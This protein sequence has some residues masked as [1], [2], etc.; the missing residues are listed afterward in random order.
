MYQ[1]KDW[2]DKYETFE[3]RKKKTLGWVLVPNR[4][5]SPKFARLITMPN[6]PAIFGVWN[7][8]LQLASRCESRGDLADSSGNAYDATDLAMTF[9]LPVEMVQESLDVLVKLGW[10]VGP[11]PSPA[12]SPAREPAPSP[13][14]N[15]AE[16]PT[17]TCT[18]AENAGLKKV[19]KK[20]KEE[21]TPSLQSGGNLKKVDRTNFAGGDVEYPTNLR[22]E[23]FKKA[24]DLWEKYHMESGRP[25]VDSQRIAH[26]SELSSMGSPNGIKSLNLA[27]KR[28][29]KAPAM[30]A[31]RSMEKS[32]EPDRRS[33]VKPN[34]VTDTKA[35]FDDFRDKLEDIVD[36]E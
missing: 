36:G 3:T 4:H 24:W 25:L 17:I 16:K 18:V 27:I 35:A 32:K 11:E 10:L 34:Q 15:T 8:I 2:N 19:S 33:A 28:G 26:L 6:G 30:V 20:K 21:E 13:A 5:D 1:I 12:P 23:A 29:F 9:R 22:H 31:E 7:M 14:R